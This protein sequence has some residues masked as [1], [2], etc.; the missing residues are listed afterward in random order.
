VIF[1][2]FFCQIDFCDAYLPLIFQFTGAIC[3]MLGPERE[4]AYF[5]GSRFRNN[6]EKFLCGLFL[7]DLLY[8]C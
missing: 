8:F 2:I 6:A 7:L 5:A 4:G 1:C 3:Q